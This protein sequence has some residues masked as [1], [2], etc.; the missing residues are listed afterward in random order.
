VGR[1]SLG[2]WARDAG[3][4]SLVAGRE[5]LVAGRWARGANRGARIAGLYLAGLVCRHTLVNDLDLVVAEIARNRGQPW[6]RNCDGGSMPIRNYRDLEAW[7]VAMDVALKA[8]ELAV[9]FPAVHRYELGTQIRK[10]AVSIP[11]NIA[12]GHAQRL[13]SVFL[14]HIRIAIGSTAELETQL[15][16][17]ARL[18][19]VSHAVAATLSS[20]LV[21]CSQLLHG[22]RRAI[23][24]QRLRTAA[25][26]VVILTCASLV[27]CLAA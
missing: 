16:F 19:I 18:K 8:Y 1:G 15:E 3:R 7:K 26:I 14:R 13:D 12:E 11:S 25:N 24:Q 2:R 22:L 20:D 23:W 5:G 10:S 17:A 4:E 27:G 21:R 6:R 9:A